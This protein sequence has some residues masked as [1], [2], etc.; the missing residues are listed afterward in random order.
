MYTRFMN[1]LPS[2]FRLAKNASLLNV[3]SPVRLRMG[4]VL[5]KKNRVLAFGSNHMKTHP[6][7]ANGVRYYSIHCEIK[8]VMIAQNLNLDI[9]G[10]DMYIYRQ[11]RDNKP[12]CARP[13]ESCFANLEEMG[14]DT[15]YF[16][17]NNE[18][19]YSWYV[20]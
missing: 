18:Q 14:I 9:R 4:A 8:T 19:G 11:T 6:H 17:E 2:Y 5:I 15:V 10:C 16:T 7:W 20:Y 13:C 12:A 1:D 3:N